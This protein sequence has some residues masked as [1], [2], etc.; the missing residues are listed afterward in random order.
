MPMGALQGAD[1]FVSSPQAPCNSYQECTLA[2]ARCKSHTSQKERRDRTVGD[3]R[4]NFLHWKSFGVQH[5]NKK[6][7]VE[8]RSPVGHRSCILKSSAVPSSAAAGSGWPV[9][10]EVAG[11]DK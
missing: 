10:G 3:I 2:E 9:G 5:T 8:E 6:V 7:L 11:H 4:L 1:S